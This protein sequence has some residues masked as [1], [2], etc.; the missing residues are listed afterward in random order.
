MTKQLEKAMQRAERITKVETAIGHAYFNIYR[1]G[2]MLGCKRIS[3]WA[4][5]KQTES[6][7]AS[8]IVVL[9]MFDIA[10]YEKGNLKKEES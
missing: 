2:K 5:D 9:G 8:L 7:Q 6:V 4:A 10:H 1:I 3:K